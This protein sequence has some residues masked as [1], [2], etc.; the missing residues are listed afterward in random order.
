MNCSKILNNFFSFEIFTLVNFSLVVFI[1]NLDIGIILS[2]DN[3]I[4]MMVVIP[5]DNFSIEMAPIRDDI[6]LARYVNIKIILILCLEFSVNF[7][8]SKCL[9]RVYE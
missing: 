6:I 8:A 2:R 7:S 5:R 1:F 4:I 3:T 9:I